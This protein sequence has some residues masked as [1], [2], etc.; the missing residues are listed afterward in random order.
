MAMS[1][2]GCRCFLFFFVSPLAPGACEVQGGEAHLRLTDQR[3]CT[4]MDMRAHV[5]EMRC[6]LVRDGL[7]LWVCRCPPAVM[8]QYGVLC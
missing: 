6:E 4:V 2:V 1:R 3:L 8:A 7:A 5:G